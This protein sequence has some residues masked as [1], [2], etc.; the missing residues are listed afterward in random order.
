MQIDNQRRPKPF[1]LKGQHEWLQ[2]VDEIIQLEELI[3]ETVSVND[4]EASGY[5]ERLRELL[6][7]RRVA[8]RR[9]IVAA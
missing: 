5:L 9:G 6:N 8:L 4:E 2:L 7:L 1:L 3:A